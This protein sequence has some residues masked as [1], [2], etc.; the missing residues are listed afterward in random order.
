MHKVVHFVHH[1]EI[2]GGSTVIIQHLRHYAARYETWVIH[3][4]SGPITQVCRELGIREIR[5]PADTKLKLPLGF[6]LLWQHLRE[7]QPDL[8]IVHGQ[9]GGPIGALAGKLAGVRRMIYIAHWVAFYTDWDLLRMI[10]NFMAEWIPIRLCQRTVVLCQS[11]YYQYLIRRF[12]IEEK[13]S[14]LSNMVDLKRVPAPGVRETI[15]REYGWSLDTIHVVCVSRLAPQKRIDWLLHSWKHVQNRGVAARL[16]IVGTGELETEL[17]ELART[18]GLEKT[19]TFLG[20]KPNG[21][22]FLMAADV[23]AMTTLYETNSVVPMEAM[24]CG[25]A[26]VASESDGVRGTLC[27]GQEGFL[28]PPGDTALF[29][30][31]MLTLIGDPEMRRRMGEAGK[32]RAKYF[33]ADMVLDRYVALFEE[34][35]AK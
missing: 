27:D 28:A 23:V 1:D 4:G 6:I 29:A 5:I 11:N 15:R 35:L 9:W 7:I 12:P 18:L 8:L 33:A 26:L 14:I 30:E 25:R 24:A 2:G 32:E 19:C 17:K 16:W 22:E 13:K 10:R 34:E 3:G 21:I 31:R 20:A